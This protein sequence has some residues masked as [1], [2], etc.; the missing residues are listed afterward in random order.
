MISGQYVLVKVL[1]QLQMATKFSLC[2]REAGGEQASS[3][4]SSCKGTDSITSVPALGH[5]AIPAASRQALPS[6]NFTPLPPLLH[7]WPQRLSTRLA[8]FIQ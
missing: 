6:S 3:L 1:F 7:A 8:L 5:L 2:P 4:A